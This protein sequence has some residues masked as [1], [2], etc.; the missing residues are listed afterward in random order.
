MSISASGF[1]PGGPNP[2]GIQIRCDTGT[3]LM[4]VSSGACVKSYSILAINFKMDGYGI[5]GEA[6]LRTK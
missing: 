4:L 6:L 5:R 2:R 3:W 1:G